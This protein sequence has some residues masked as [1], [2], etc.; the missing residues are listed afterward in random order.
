[1]KGVEVLSGLVQRI[2]I[3][4]LRAFF[5]YLQAFDHNF[6]WDCLLLVTGISEALDEWGN[7]SNIPLAEVQ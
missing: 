3:G 1:M 7:K 5:S 4:E 6:L 2:R